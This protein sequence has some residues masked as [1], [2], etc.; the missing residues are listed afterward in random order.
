MK[1]ASDIQTLRNHLRGFSQSNQ[2]VG[3]V[4][5]MGA[6]HKG[7]ISL[8]QSSKRQNDKT[9][10]SIY[11]NP[12]QFGPKEDLASYFRPIEKDKELA[13]SFG[14][15]VLFLPDDSM[16]YP[17]HTPIRIHEAH[18]SNTLCGAYRP[19]HFDGVC[20]VVA[21]LLHLVQPTRLYLGKKDAQQL[22]VLTH[23]VRALFFD[24]EVVGAPT[25]REEDGL[26]CS[27]RNGYLT[28]QERSIAPEIYRALTKAAVEFEE[29][30]RDRK[31][32][33]RQA[34]DHLQTIDPIDVQYLELLSWDRFEADDVV[35]TPSILA[36]AAVLGKTRLID[37]VWLTP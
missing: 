18:F 1:I 11:V 9:V 37:N 5:T 34:Q 36:I 31:K 6:L 21:K 2:T 25:V 29:G 22:R 30:E 3:F 35:T 20:T 8:V 28:P 23:M 12:T 15:D 7:H 19:G 14:V 10:M 4:P 13:Q 24:V 33:L 26:A 16:M 17:E 32:L 27:S